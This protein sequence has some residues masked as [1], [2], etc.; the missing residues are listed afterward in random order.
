MW[1]MRSTFVCT[2]VVLLWSAPK[3]EA[4]TIF[5]AAGGNLQ[6]ALNDAQPGDTILLAAGCRIRRQL[7]PAR[8]E[9]RRLYHHPQLDAGH[10]RCREPAGRIT[11]SACAAAGAPALAE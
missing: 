1:T 4:A 8:E 6:K 9:R 7:R 3:L 5:V 11:A 2:L 10:G